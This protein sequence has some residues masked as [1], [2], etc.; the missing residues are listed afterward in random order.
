MQ[1]KGKENGISLHHVQRRELLV[2]HYV[3][4]FLIAFAGQHCRRPLPCVGIVRKI[5]TFS[6]NI[7]G[8]IVVKFTF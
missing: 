7:P 8:H 6:L 4:T 5:K 1:S 2:N 3:V